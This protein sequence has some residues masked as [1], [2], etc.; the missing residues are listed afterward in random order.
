MSDT[1]ICGPFS[2]SDFRVMQLLKRQ[3]NRMQAKNNPVFNDLLK[4]DKDTFTHKYLR[5]VS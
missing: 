4:R 5:K 2:E 3:I 1:V